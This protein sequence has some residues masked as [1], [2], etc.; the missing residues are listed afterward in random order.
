M[1]N[2]YIVYEINLQPSDIGKDFVFGN[3]L[4]GVAKLT[5]NSDRSIYKC[6][7]YGISFDARGINSLSDG[8]RFSNICNII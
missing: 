1:F 4:F 6:S 3:S 8:R 5:K 7:G 2:I